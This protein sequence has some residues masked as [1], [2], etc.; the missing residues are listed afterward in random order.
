VETGVIGRRE[1]LVEELVGPAFDPR[2]EEPL[3][4]LAIDERPLV[5]HLLPALE[6]ALLQV[7]EDHAAGQPELGGR[8]ADR[9]QVGL[10]HRPYRKGCARPRVS[11]VVH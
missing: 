10:S 4:L 1:R 7:L 3:Q 8:L 11:T 5:A 6:L 2:L 9:D